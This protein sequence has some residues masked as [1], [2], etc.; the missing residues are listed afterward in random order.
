[1][2][3][4]AL[5]FLTVNN[6]IRKPCIR[7]VR[8][9]MLEWLMLCIILAN[10]VTLC[11][12]SNRPGFL[13]TQLYA[14]LRVLNYFFIAAFTLE[15]VI[16]VTALGF[17]IGKHTYL[18][19][20]WNVLDFIVV[21]FGWLE[22]LPGVGNYT[23]IRVARILRPLRLVTKIESL[24]I[25]VECMLRSLPM[26]A[27]VA[28]LAM[29]F[30]AIFGIASVEL[31]KGRMS[32]RCGAPDLASFTPANLINGTYQFISYTVSDDESTWP[33][34]GPMASSVTWSDVNG[35]PTPSTLAFGGPSSPSNFGR[36][37]PSVPSTNPN[38]PNSPYGL[39]CV[40]YANPTPYGNYRHW[41][42]ILTA[43]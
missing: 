15:M 43:W 31:L 30:Y 8:W 21:I 26:L 25:L 35:T 1:M 4:L 41:D 11:L 18:R 38:D 14:R 16:K 34:S 17:V 12:D 23:I 9:K 10:C 36:I 40:P 27:D 28:I 13:E 6:P 7:L 22:L 32:N 33:C 19:N 29:F 3:P 2:N 42:N 39:L 20:G 5:G 24:R 37:C